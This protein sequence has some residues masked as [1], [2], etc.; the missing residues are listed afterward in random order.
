MSGKAYL[1][2][3]GPGRADLITVRGL[4]VLR[5]ADVV[6][7]DRLISPALLAEAP[8]QAER[9]FVGK[10]PGHHTVRQDRINEALVHLVR[11][12][13]QVVRLKG[14]DPGVF[15]HLAEE[16]ASLAEAG[17]PFEIVPG[18]SAALA[19]PLYAGIPLTWR[20][21]AAGFAVVSGHEATPTGCSGIDWQ[22]LA[23]MPTLVVLMAQSRLDQ[24]CRYLQ[25]AGRDPTTPA[26]LISRG[27]S[28]G[29]QTLLATLATLPMRQQA[30]RLP[31]P[32]VLV[33][34][35]VAALAETLRWFDP[36]TLAAEPM[37]WDEL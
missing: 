25:A 22:A 17:L 18:V 36:Q 10:R 30:A 7:Y 21:V 4:T 28:A 27:A 2:G 31:E 1:V 24:V 20:S 5:Q 11:K 37:L 23:A 32:A 9:I 26:A 15:A 13:L 19:V 8:A 3:A 6:L 33:V 12:G 29:Q 34:G 35:A 16:A 14:G